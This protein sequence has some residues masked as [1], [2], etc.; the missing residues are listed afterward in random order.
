MDPYEPEHTLIPCCVHLRTKTQFYL[1]EEMA[2]GPGMIRVSTTANYWCTRTSTP[3]GPDEKPCTPE[4][5]QCGR[6]CHE[7]AR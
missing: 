4:S 7:A 3:R 5:C 2:A 1:P 6:G